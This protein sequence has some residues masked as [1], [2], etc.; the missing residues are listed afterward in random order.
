MFNLSRPDARPIKPLR[1]L[2][3][4][5]ARIL[6]SFAEA[7][8]D[9]DARRGPRAPPRRDRIAW[10]DGARGVLIVFVVAYHVCL[11]LLRA[12]L[13]P[14]SHVAWQLVRLGG[15]LRMPAFFLCAGITSGFIIARPFGRFVDRK[16][17]S[18]LYPYVVWATLTIT[19][20]ESIARMSGGTTGW[21]VTDFLTGHIAQYWFLHTLFVSLILAWVGVRRAGARNWF[22]IT[23]AVAIATDLPTVSD[24]LP[25]W[26]RTTSQNLPFVALGILVTPHSYPGRLPTGWRRGLALLIAVAIYAW[27]GPLADAKVPGAKFVAGVAGAAIVV[28]ALSWLYDSAR[29]SGWTERLTFAL[30]WIGQRSLEIYVAHELLTRPWR[31][32]VV[33]WGTDV[34][35]LSILAGIVV[36]VSVSILLAEAVRRR[37][38]SFIYRYPW[39]IV[40]DKQETHHLEDADGQQPGG[41]YGDDPR[42]HDAPQDGEIELASFAEARPYDGTGGRM[43]GADR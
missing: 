31:R 6:G 39:P 30:R 27:C 42:Q 28:F 33:W 36:A 22:L 25:L 1:P 7:V 26:L 29:P 23:A 32:I 41:R 9:S 3:V 40:S 11:E 19:I 24:H 34:L 12:G 18:I 17:R 37:G 16:L 38:W 15:Y 8:P 21:G 14:E 10:L 43:G 4:V 35:V 20:R 5:G 2:L 13:M